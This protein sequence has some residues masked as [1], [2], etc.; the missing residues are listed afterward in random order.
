MIILSL[1][2]LVCGF[3][4]IFEAKGQ[5]AYLPIIDGAEE[6]TYKTEDGINLNLWV[7][8]PDQ[9]NKSRCTEL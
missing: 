8:R 5:Y 6:L 9:L 2:I 4:L 3:S 7:F 1:V